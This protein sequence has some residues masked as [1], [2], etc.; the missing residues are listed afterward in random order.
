MSINTLDSRLGGIL[1]PCS[2]RTARGNLGIRNPQSAIHNRAAGGAPLAAFLVAAIAS[3]ALPAADQPQ[4]G[5]RFTRNMVSAER[6]LPD[7][8]DPA[9]GRNVKWSAALGTETNGSP[10]VAAGA[11]LVGTNR[12]AAGDGRHRGDRGVLMCFGQADGKLRWQLVVPK[13]EDDRFA[14]W[15]NVG[16]MSPPTVEGGRAYVVSNRGEVL[17][18]D[19]AG[20]ANGNDGPYRD[21]GKHMAAAGKA[22][23]AVEPSDADIVWRYDMRYT[24]GVRQ[25]NGSNGSI[26]LH[27]RLLYVSTSNGVDKSHR[28]IPAPDAPSLIVLDK[29]TGRLVA[30]D[31]ARMGPQVFHG[32]WS[33]P[34]LGT[35]GGRELVFFGGGDGVCYAFEAL[36]RPPAGTEPAALKNV[37]RFHCDPAGRSDNPHQY[38]NNRRESPSTIIGMPVFHDGRI[39]VTAGGDAWHG[40]RQAWLKCIDASKAGDVT[41]SAGLWSYPLNRHCLATPSIAGGLVYATDLG[42]VVHCVDAATGK[43]CWTHKAGGEIWSSTLV[44]DG[45][46]YVGS[47]RGDF[48]ILAA[49]REKRVIHTARFASGINTTAT[50]AGGVLYV[51]TNR[52]LYAIA[53]TKD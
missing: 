9:A 37:W 50:A 31:K 52:R 14:D 30:T 22:P 42:R 23:L 43:P 47:R 45:K 35:V 13:L 40:K 28:N 18:L 36:T 48:W 27:G 7:S 1:A 17:C 4:W 53:R 16:I 8:F 10:I 3:S 32:M 12:A 25:H 11:V 15:H 6:G 5:Q 41:G 33:S 24:L 39:Y 26:L 38:H 2:L 51:A 34:S 29:A 19:L 44:A 49:G 21:E 20:L 46:V